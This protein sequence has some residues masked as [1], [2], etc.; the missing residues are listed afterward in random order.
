[1]SSFLN[2]AEK[3]AMIFL[4]SGFWNTPTGS[5]NASHRHSRYAAYTSIM[6][7]PAATTACLQCGSSTAPPPAVNMRV[8]V[9][10]T[11]NMMAIWMAITVRKCQPFFLSGNAPQLQPS[12]LSCFCDMNTAQ[13]APAGTTSHASRTLDEHP[14]SSRSITQHCVA[15][16]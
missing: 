15:L 2:P 8:S 9:N 10:F 16:L 14:M 1:M 6:F 5:S 12:G 13:P 11:G 7:M 3:A 4:I